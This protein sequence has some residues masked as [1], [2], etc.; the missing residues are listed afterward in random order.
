MTSATLSAP[1]RGLFLLPAF[2]TCALVL[3]SHAATRYVSTTGSDGNSGSFNFPY[4]TISHAVDRASPGDTIF[5]RGGVYSELVEIFDSGTAG[6]PIIVENYNGETPILDGTAFV[7]GGQT[8][9]VSFFGADHITFR[10]FEI[11]NLTAL[12]NSRTPLGI[13]I[14]GNADGITIDS[15]HIHDIT[16]TGDNGNAHGILVSGYTTSIQDLLIEN[17]L[18]EDLVL[19]NSE[20]LSINGNVDG[21]V[22]RG[23]TV[24]NCNNIGIDFIGF[25]G[26]HPDPALDMA[27]NGLCADNIVHGC[28]TV[29]NPAYGYWS[30]AGIYVDGGRDIIIENNQTYQ[31]DIGIELASENIGFATRNVHVRNNLVW[32]NNYVG[33][34]TGGYAPNVGGTEDCVITGN[35]LYQNDA[36]EDGNGELQVR[37]KTYGLEVKGNIIF[38]GDQGLVINKALTDTSGLDFDYNIYKATWDFEWTWDSGLWRSGLALW[39]ST[40][41]MDANSLSVDPG[42]TLVSGPVAGFDFQ[43]DINSPAFEAG[44]PSYVPDAG[45]VDS[46]GNTRLTGTMDIGAHELPVVPTN[47]QLWRKSHFGIFTDSGDAADAADADCDGLAN[48]AEFAIGSDPTVG[49]NAGIALTDLEYHVPVSASAASEVTI[50][51]RIS[52]TM[53]AGT[54]QT[55]ATRPAGGSWAGTPGVSAAETAG[56]L[57]LTDDRSSIV[58]RFYRIEVSR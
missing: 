40:T 37:Y 3:S 20:A 25:E 4:K 24:R 53:Q 29:A 6:S 48:L 49:T 43:I 35:T 31:N 41:G 10:G 38:A 2:F 42:F 30:C 50:V 51:V 46:Y 57:I 7:A 28:S 17:C 1:L 27:R 18:I 54:W 58:R 19:G 56:V 23:N 33:V 13:L 22:V 11:R 45:E 52:P 47:L 32:R 26:V 21:F 5:V 44:P 34:L 15:C 14:D 9:V 12:V 36:A 55:V 16:H 8:A 39:Q